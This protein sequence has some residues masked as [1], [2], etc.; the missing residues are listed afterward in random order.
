MARLTFR[1]FSKYLYLSPPQDACPTNSLRRARGIDP[2]PTSSVRSRRG[3]SIVNTYAAKSLFVFE[4]TL[5]TFNGSYLYGFPA[6]AQLVTGTNLSFLSCPPTADKTDWLFISN[7][8]SLYKMDP[9]AHTYSRWGITPPVDGFTAIAASASSV[10]ISLCNNHADWT[11]SGCTGTDDTTYKIEGTGSINCAVAT[12]VTGTMTKNMTLDL[13]QFSASAPSSDADYISMHVY[14][15]EPDNL[16][17]IQIQFS[18]N[19]TSFSPDVLSYTFNFNPSSTSTTAPYS[20]NGLKLY[21]GL[22]STDYYSTPEQEQYT[23]ESLNTALP[24]WIQNKNWWGGV[25][26]SL[27]NGT[28]IDYDIADWQHLH[29]AKSSFTRSGSGAY[30]WSDVKSVRIK[31]KANSLG[32]VNVK[33]DQIEMF[34]GV[35]M[36]GDYKYYITYYNEDS[37]TDSNPNPTAVTI[38]N[39][40]RSGVTLANLPVPTDTQITH[41]KI[42]RTVG[43]GSIPFLCDT[44]DVADTTYTDIIADCYIMDTSTN[45]EYLSS[46][47]ISFDNILPDH[48][49]GYCAYLQAV[50]FWTNRSAIYSGNLYYSRI[51]YTESNEGFI[52]VTTSGDPLQIPI[53]W[54]GVLYVFSKAH[55]YQVTGAN[56][57]YSREVYGVPGTVKPATVTATPYGIMYQALDGI[58]LFNGVRSERM[59][60]KQ[61]GKLLSGEACENLTAFVGTCAAWHQ[62][63]YYISDGAQTLAYHVTN[64][65]WRD[66]G[67]GYDC[68]FND[69]Q[70]GTLY[71]GNSTGVYKL[72][73]T[74]VT[75]DASTA[76][77]FEIQTA[78]IRLDADKQVMVNMLYV[79]LDT[80]GEQ[81]DITLIHESGETPLGPVQTTSRQTVSL[82]I[83]RNYNRL[84]VRLDGLINQA[85]EIFGIEFDADVSKAT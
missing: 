51:G 64:D 47:A 16:E 15:D 71:A 69:Q 74:G 4:G 42:W 32:A 1:D 41:K 27:E 78:Q 54:N 60:W 77:S 57:Y 39:I 70:T 5:F 58:R 66:V 25:R 22:G 24:T 40:L 61:L 21:S 67:V 6:A 52:R 53:V 17:F 65:T 82:P 62:D 75:A 23:Q 73:Q 76:F 84:A 18:L 30:D 3:S 63:E 37:G 38:N 83:G 43:D 7:G 72:N 29:V 33:F 44:I 59:G 13:S 50:T 48:D 31:V 9:A 36:Q 79:D 11:D 45:A 8:S 14:I 20:L 55:L 10:P 26:S 35:G 2:I 68:F 28:L 80:Q 49:F 56:P 19:N 81:L 46:E 12:G 34:G 85:I